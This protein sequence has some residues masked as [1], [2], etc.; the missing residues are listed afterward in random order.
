MM[1]AALTSAY[2]VKRQQPGWTSFDVPRAFWYSSA[3]ILSSSLAVQLAVR[4]F[5]QREMQLYRRYISL[6]ALLG[7]VFILLQWLGFR[8]IW[9]SGITLHGSGVA[10]FYILSPGCMQCTQVGWR[11]NAAGNIYQGI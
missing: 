11:N 2:I 3:V 6:T 9:N 5:K 1:F 8:Q 10:S 4:S 7:V